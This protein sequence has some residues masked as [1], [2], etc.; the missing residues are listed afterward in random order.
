MKWI[1]IL[2]VACAAMVG[3]TRTAIC[4]NAKKVTA[5]ASP[6]IASE[7]DCEFPDEITK[8]LD[9]VVLVKVTLCP[10]VAPNGPLGEFVCPIAYGAIDSALKAGLPASAKCKKVP[11]GDA[12]KGLFMPVCLKI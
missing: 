6:L 11:G 2:V 8:W 4:D 7:G 5:M 3:C 1:L 12:L 9:E 10:K